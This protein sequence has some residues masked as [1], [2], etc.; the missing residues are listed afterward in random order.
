VVY[1][2]GHAVLSTHDRA[3]QGGSAGEPS[4]PRLW[5]AITT[6]A[7]AR[8]AKYPSPAAAHWVHEQYV[9]KGGQFVQS[10]QKQ[11]K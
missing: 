8:F 10:H 1:Q 6:M 9:L 4:N 11:R 7:R 3:H 5:N 2:Q